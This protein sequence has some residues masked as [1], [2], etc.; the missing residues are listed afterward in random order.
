[1]K[2]YVVEFTLRAVVMA[3]DEAHAHCV[4]TDEF[5][6]IARDD[7]PDVS[8]EREVHGAPDLPSG[9]DLDCLPYGGDGNAML[10]ELIGKPPDA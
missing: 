3:D 1:M 5:R 8:V 9:W 6:D 7:D 10:R 4:A 2:P